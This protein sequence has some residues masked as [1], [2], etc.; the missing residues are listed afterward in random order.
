MIKRR[1]EI[2]ESETS[3]T[4]A[5]AKEKLKVAQMLETLVED[6][7]KKHDLSVKLDW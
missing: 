5:E 7:I 2:E 6:T 1:H 3:N 4:V